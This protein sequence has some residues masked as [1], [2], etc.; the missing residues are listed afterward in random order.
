MAHASRNVNHGS[1]IK[2]ERQSREAVTIRTVR[3]RGVR[4]GSRAGDV[5]PVMVQRHRQ[6]LSVIGSPHC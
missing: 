5:G 6:T 1:R 4:D 3:D 2:N